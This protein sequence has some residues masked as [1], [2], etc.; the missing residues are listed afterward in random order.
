MTEKNKN[1]NKVKKER[2]KSER[3]SYEIGDDIVDRRR[4]VER[5]VTKQEIDFPERRKSQRRRPV[6]GVD[7]QDRRN[8]ERRNPEK[9]EN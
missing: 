2:R 8:G 6:V 9:K 1:I 3:R 7:F 5:R 4:N